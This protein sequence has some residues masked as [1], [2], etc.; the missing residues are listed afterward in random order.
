M[1][2]YNILLAKF[3]PIMEGTFYTHYILTSLRIQKL[4][5]SK[6]VVFSYVN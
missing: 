2:K 5:E 1:K 4:S 6:M 3:N